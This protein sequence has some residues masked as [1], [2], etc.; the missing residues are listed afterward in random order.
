MK[1]KKSNGSVGFSTTKTTFDS[2]CRPHDNRPRKQRSRQGQ[3][4]SWKKDQ[5]YS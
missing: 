4:R 1:N 3:K 2:G 5:G